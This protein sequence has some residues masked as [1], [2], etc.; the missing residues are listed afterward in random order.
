MTPDDAMGYPGAVHADTCNLLVLPGSRPAWAGGFS[1]RSVAQISRLQPIV[2]CRGDRPCVA[3][4]RITVCRRQPCGAAPAHYSSLYRVF[5]NRRQAVPA[6]G[7]GG[8]LLTRWPFAADWYISLYG[9]ANDRGM[10]AF[11]RIASASS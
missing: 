9:I 1:R 3:A 7:G 4:T 5:P 8:W 6:V 11:G 2:S 10:V